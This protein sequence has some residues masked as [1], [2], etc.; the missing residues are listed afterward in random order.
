MEQQYP[1]LT[2]VT[3]KIFKNNAQMIRNIMYIVTI[4]M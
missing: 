3:L 1:R 2:K 4:K